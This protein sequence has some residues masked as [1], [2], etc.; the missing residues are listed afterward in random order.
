MPGNSTPDG[1]QSG[2]QSGPDCYAPVM[3]ARRG[4]SE[5]SIYF[6]HDAPCREPKDHKRCSSSWRG[7]V[8]LGFGPGGNRMRRK[9]RRRTKTEVKDQ[10]RELHA[11]ID[12]DIRRPQAPTTVR[13]ALQRDMH[14]VW[15]YWMSKA[16]RP[17]GPAL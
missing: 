5:D 12:E 16:H 10:L 3:A 9:V 4:R 14:A 2:S 7:T 1:S 15:A 13:T 6:D 17:A 11:D 8:S